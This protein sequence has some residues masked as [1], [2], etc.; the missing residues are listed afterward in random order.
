MILEPLA[1]CFY[2]LLSAP[3]IFPSANKVP[4]MSIIVPLVVVGIVLIA[5]LVALIFRRKAVAG[6]LDVEKGNA[7]IRGER[8]QITL[9]ILT[10]RGNL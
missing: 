1:L 2:P 7:Q 4:V 3:G 9:N 10:Q 5:A 8:G 6:K